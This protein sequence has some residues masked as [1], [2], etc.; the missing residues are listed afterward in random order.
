VKLRVHAAFGAADQPTEIPLLNRRLDAASIMTVFGLASPSGADWV[1]TLV[2]GPA[3]KPS[4]RAS[5]LIRLHADPDRTLRSSV[6][7]VA[8]LWE[9][10]LSAGRR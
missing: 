1:V 9:L 8:G 10:R 2:F 3:Q 6:R 4:V 5:Q 7:V